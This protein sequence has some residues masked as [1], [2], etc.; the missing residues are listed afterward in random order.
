MNSTENAAHMHISVN[1][2]Y[3]VVSA[4]A[5]VLSLA[6]LIFILL[7]QCS[8]DPA[9]HTPFYRIFKVNV[10]YAVGNMLSRTNFYAC[11]GSPL[12]IIVVDS[13]SKW[14]TGAL[15]SIQFSIPVGITVA[16]PDLEYTTNDRGCFTYREHDVSVSILRSTIHSIFVFPSLLFMKLTVSKLRE[17]RNKKNVSPVARRQQEGL[18][19]YT[20]YCAI[21]QIVQGT[22]ILIRIIIIEER[23]PEAYHYTPLFVYIMNL[24][25]ENLPTILLIVLS[26]SV[27][28]RLIRLITCSAS[29]FQ[30]VDLPTTNSA[31]DY[32]FTRKYT[33]SA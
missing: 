4:I 1:S 21:I 24:S 31:N 20:I 11:F 18:I 28:R 5:I 9:L 17:F 19:K 30:T 27:R 32:L 15:F 8:R 6:N 25:Y 26:N 14:R 13:W 7:L 3:R 16:F 29:T 10:L 2:V 33:P 22:V 12:E 23:I